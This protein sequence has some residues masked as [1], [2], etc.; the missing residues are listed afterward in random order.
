VATRNLRITACREVYRGQGAKGE[1]VIYEIEAVDANTGVLINVP[2]RSF[3]HLT[4]GETGQFEVEKYERPGKETT[5]T[6][7]KPKG[8]GGN[9]L[10]P[11]VDDLRKRVELLEGNYDILKRAVAALEEQ[12]RQQSPPPV[13]AGGGSIHTSGAPSLAGGPPDD[14]I[15]F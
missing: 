14:D 13:A 2:L 8:S 11:K 9:A 12:V 15:P 1:Y 4:E 3:S 5:Y 6:L 7:K 10:G